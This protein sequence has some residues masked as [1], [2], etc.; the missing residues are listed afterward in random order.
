MDDRL[1]DLDPYRLVEAAEAILYSREQMIATGRRPLFPTDLIGA[2]DQPACYV[3]FTRTEL[4]EAA[5][6]LVRLGLVEPR[7]PRA[8]RR[9]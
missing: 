3:E 2:A 9:A 4:E 6:F 7:S 8:E 5:A 1:V